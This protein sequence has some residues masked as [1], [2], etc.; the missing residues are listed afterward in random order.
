MKLD[1]K[2]P[3]SPPNYRY[4]PSGSVS[5]SLPHSVKSL[6][7]FASFTRANAL[8]ASPSSKTRFYGFEPKNL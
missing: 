8:G 1:T 3:T 6:T 7:I 5:F 4:A 2:S